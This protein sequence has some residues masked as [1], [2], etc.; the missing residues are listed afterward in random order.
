[1]NVFLY[2]AIF[3]NQGTLAIIHK[4]QRLTPPYNQ[5]TARLWVDFIHLVGAHN[6]QGRGRRKGEER[7]RH[8]FPS[9]PR[10]CLEHRSYTP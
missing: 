1:M 10:R 6:E 7:F 3:L 2:Y 4:V 8:G 5:F 9:F